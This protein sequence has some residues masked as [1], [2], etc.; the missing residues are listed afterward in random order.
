M[1]SKHVA[2]SK[3]NI[4]HVK[5]FLGVYV[6]AENVMHVYCDSQLHDTVLIVIINM[7][8]VLGIF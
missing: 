5:L 3:I 8:G 6:Q 1:R 4:A 7:H 2:L